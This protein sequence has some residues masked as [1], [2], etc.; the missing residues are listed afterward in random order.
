MQQHNWDLALNQQ[1]RSTFLLSLCHCLA[2]HWSEHQLGCSSRYLHCPRQQPWYLWSRHPLVPPWPRPPQSGLFCPEYQGLVML[3]AYSSLRDKFFAFLWQIIAP[4]NITASWQVFHRSVTYHR[5]M[6]FVQENSSRSR[7]TFGKVLVRFHSHTRCMHAPHIRAALHKQCDLQFKGM[8]QST[9]RQEANPTKS[10]DGVLT[11]KD[12]AQKHSSWA[13]TSESE[14]YWWN[15]S[16]WIIHFRASLLK[17][18]TVN[19]S[20]KKKVW[21]IFWYH[22]TQSQSTAMWIFEN[23]SFC[24]RARWFCWKKITPSKSTV[25]ESCDSKSLSPIT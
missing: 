12:S 9:L 21:S 6:T 8:Q 23:E 25:I 15:C 20:M 1:S 16:D 17:I 14:A 2:S 11:S 22:I 19:L 5:I 18:W 7:T 4:W 24:A 3:C 13:F 10:S